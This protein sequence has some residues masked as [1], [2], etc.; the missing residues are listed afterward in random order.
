MLWGIGFKEPASAPMA[1]HGPALD[2]SEELELHRREVLPLKRDLHILRATQLAH[3]H[4][5]GSRVFGILCIYKILLI[6]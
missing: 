1:V 2:P 4:L 6:P 3:T 5:E